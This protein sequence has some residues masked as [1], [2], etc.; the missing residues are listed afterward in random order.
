VEI[1]VEHPGP[2][3]PVV[4]HPNFAAFG[5]SANVQFVKGLVVAKKSG[6]K[7]RGLTLQQPTGPQG[8]WIIQFL[9]EDVHP[10][11]ETYT[12]YVLE[13]KQGQA[14]LPLD[15]VKGIAIKE[16]FG[17]INVTYPRS[18]G[19][20]CTQ[21]AA[22]GTSDKA[23]NMAAS[24]NPSTGFTVTQTSG[25]PNW[26]FSCQAPA[27]GPGQTASLTISQPGATPPPDPTPQTVDNLT[28]KPCQQG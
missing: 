26:V 11:G 14:G 1:G 28:I 18:P 24:L 13:D 5:Q 21:F 25:P 10:N 27:T 20:I 7:I 12:L 6:M 4:H 8:F 17:G 3:Y 16:G 23:G 22:Y 2:D 9:L 15:S 19:T